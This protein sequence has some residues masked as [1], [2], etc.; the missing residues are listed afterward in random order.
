MRVSRTA[1]AFA[2]TVAW[3]VVVA[4]LLLSDLGA[5]RKMTPNEWG[6]F[7]AGAFAPLAFLWLVVGYMQ[8]G[9]ELRLSTEALRLQAEELKNS[10]EQQRALVEVSRQQVEA[11]R[12]ALA[13]ERKLREDL[14]LPKLTLHPAG[15]GASGGGRRTYRFSMSNSGHAAT[16][17]SVR[18]V[19]T[20]QTESSFLLAPLFDKGAQREFQIDREQPIATR[21]GRML[22]EYTDGLGRRRTDAYRFGRASDED[23]RS[24]LRF[25]HCD[26]TLRSSG[27]PTAGHQGPVRGTVYIFSARALASC[28]RRP[29]SS[30]VRHQRAAIAARQ[31]SQRLSA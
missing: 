5:A 9:E 6:D 27:A 28:R 3:L 30:N 31:Q 16:D 26:L 18:A 2:G 17:L 13:H 14:S 24:L 22:I 10:V 25:E 15:G 21:A 4:Y 29:L 8:Q 23:D 11:E 7:L 12:E 20:D 1:L 19:F